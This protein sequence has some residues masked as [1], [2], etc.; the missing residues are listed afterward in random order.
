MNLSPAKLTVFVLAALISTQAH[1]HSWYPTDCCHDRDCRPVPVESVR[2]TPDGYLLSDGTLIPYAEAKHS[3]DGQFH[4]CRYE[5]TN[6]VILDTERKPCFW[7][8]GYGS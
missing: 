4:I 2:E 3:P 5:S 6:N 7:A 1:A 8:P